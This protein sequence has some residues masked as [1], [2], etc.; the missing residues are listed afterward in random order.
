MDNLPDRRGGSRFKR[1]ICHDNPPPSLIQ[2]DT[3]SSATST[4]ENHVTG[5]VWCADPP[6]ETAALRHNRSGA[7]LFL[8][9]FRPAP[10][11]CDMTGDLWSIGPNTVAEKGSEL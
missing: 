6:F 11:S 8:A 2:S 7:R 3:R 1:R 9:G 5:N 10:A 4:E